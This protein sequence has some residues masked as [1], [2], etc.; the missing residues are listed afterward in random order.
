[1]QTKF[2]LENQLEILE[3]L[4]L[5]LEIGFPLSTSLEVM[6]LKFDVN[7]YL[8]KLEN[9][10]TFYD[11]MVSE[12]FDKDV[13]LIIK[14][15]LDSEDFRATIKKSTDILKNKIEKRKEIME[16]LKYPIMLI[17]LAILSVGFI[18]YFLLPQFKQILYSFGVN[19]QATNIIYSMFSL[20]PYVITVLVVLL[21][22]ITL[23]FLRLNFDTKLDF[24]VKFKPIRKIYVSLYNQVFVVTLSNLLKTKLHLSVVISVLAN[25]SENKLLAKE[26]KK[27]ENG[28]KNGK[29]ISECITPIYYDPQLI[30]I[31]KLGEE[32]GM[33][34]YYLDS[35]SKILT[36]INQN[37]GKKIIFWI[38]PI[39]YMIFGIL[40]LLLYASIFIP[41][42]ELMDSI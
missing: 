23:M 9:G 42:F 32:S 18:T 31:L 36:A 40:I 8:K 16:L 34:I 27:I 22:I 33:L 19:S 24:F 37:R 3:M 14:L 35:Y 28:L 11:V 39:F 5:L 25:Q 2:K 15:G 20:G 30:K 41:M 12:G 7:K 38:Q 29:Y 4:L 26:A 13:L 1:M 6:S 21:A 17:I 10:V